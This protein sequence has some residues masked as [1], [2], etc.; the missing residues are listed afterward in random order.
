MVELEGHASKVG[1]TGS[2]LRRPVQATESREHT[3]DTS[4]DV[5]ATRVAGQTGDTSKTIRPSRVAARN[6][7]Q[8]WHEQ[9]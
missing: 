7:Q 1:A 3:G 5:R 8:I 4:K 9:L 6:A 2:T